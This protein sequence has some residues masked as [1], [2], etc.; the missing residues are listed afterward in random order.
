MTYKS[1]LLMISVLMIFPISAAGDVQHRSEAG[2][3]RGGAE[4]SLTSTES[5][6]LLFMRE[7]EKLARD[8]Y[9]ELYEHYKNKGIELLIF[10]RIAESEQEHMDAMLKVLD[11]YGIDDP[12]EGMS[13][14]EFENATL[15]TLYLNMVSDSDANSTVLNEPVTGGKVNELAALQVGAWI[16]ERDMLDIMHAISN[17]NKADIVQVYTNLLCGSRSHLRAFVAQIGADN[18]EAQILVAADEIAVSTTPEETL[19]Y[20]LGNESDYLCF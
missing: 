16:E 8:V 19:D 6:D 11:K 5:A 13:R 4:E 10:A 12:A 2:K 17:T 14:G 9:D 18:Y 15:K 7:E 3:N 20:W 1:I